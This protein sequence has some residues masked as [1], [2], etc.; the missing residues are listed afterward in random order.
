MLLAVKAVR[1]GTLGTNM[2]ARTFSITSSTL[3]D[4]FSGRVK[5]GMK[6]GP[7]PYFDESEEKRVV[8]FMMKSAT[9]GYGKTKQEVFAIMERTLKNKGKLT[10]NFNGE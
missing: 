2:A 5:H 6:S 4:R 7:V 1:D 3:K 10:D 9:M 8:E